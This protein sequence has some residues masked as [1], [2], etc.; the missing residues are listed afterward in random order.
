MSVDILACNGKKGYKRRDDAK[1][2]LYNARRNYPKL[3]FDMYRCPICG[4]WHVGH[5]RRTRAA[6]F[7]HLLKKKRRQ[8]R[9]I[10][11]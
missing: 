4:L 6:K 7:D 3:A 9:R 10:E 5:D 8:H 11:K 2:A 1:A